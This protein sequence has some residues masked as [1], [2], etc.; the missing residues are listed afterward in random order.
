MC[1][2]VHIYIYIYIYTHTHTST[3]I[4]H[5]Y[6]SPKHTHT[7]THTQVHAN[8]AA[9]LVGFVRQP[10]TPHWQ[11]VP[12]S[13]NSS[14]LGTK[15]FEAENI[16]Q[17]LDRMLCGSSTT[18]QYGLMVLVEMVRNCTQTRAT[19]QTQAV[20]GEV[21]KKLGE[22]VNILKNPLPA[23]PI[24]NTSGTLSPPLGSNR[25]R[26]IEVIFELVLMKNENVEEKLIEF[27]A[28]PACLDLM[29]LYEWN[30][31]LHNLVRK[32]IEDVLQ[33][34]NE[35]LKRSLFSDGRIL[36]VIMDAHANN[37]GYVKQPKSCRKGYMGHLRL[38]SNQII[39]QADLDEW[40]WEFTE[41]E[42]WRAYVKGKLDPSNALHDRHRANTSTK[43]SQRAPSHAEDDD[44]DDDFHGH[45]MDFNDIKGLI[46]FRG[47]EQAD[48][49]FEDGVCLCVSVGVCMI[50]VMFEDDV[51][52]CVTV[53]VWFI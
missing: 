27:K 30:N 26:I 12:A 42:R 37:D 1:V 3:S 24:T 34:G 2:C 53:C 38:I 43:S 7:H 19:A 14:R 17:I 39:K 46:H 22:L 33:W 31:F 49:L 23:D 44:D 36:D 8:A 45:N 51:C 20:V 4:T 52:V 50:H 35:T 16:G 18:L 25:M 10:S 21:S 6:L 29:I 48:E 47:P 13:P 41:S 9:A 5:K 32:M 15:L 40:M 28:L 11:D